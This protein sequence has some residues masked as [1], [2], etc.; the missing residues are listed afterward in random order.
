MIDPTTGIDSATTQATQ[1]TPATTPTYTAPT[2]TPGQNY[3]FDPNQYL[4]GIQKTAASIYDPQAAQLKALQQ[5]S[6]NQM[7]NTKVTTEKQ[8]QNEL[9]ARIEAINSRGA[10]FGGGAITNQNDINTRKTAALTN[11]D[12]NQAAADAQTQGQLG[13]LQ[14]NESQYIQDQ[15]SGQN[16]SM[17]SKWA[18]SRNFYMQQANFDQQKAESQRS[19][20]LQ[21]K[22][23]KATLKQN[24]K[25]YKKA[26]KQ[27][28]QQQAQFDQELTY[29]YAALNKSGSN[30][31]NTNSSGSTSTNTNIY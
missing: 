27:L 7:A 20:D 4:P 5:I 18:D 10:F 26:K 19:Y 31:T 14:A 12:L 13:S 25:E 16:N 24:S 22:Q 6:Q 9:T 3:S 21:V 23:L 1:A 11:L 17:Y 28:D 30:S 2:Y 15:L 29:K 8:F